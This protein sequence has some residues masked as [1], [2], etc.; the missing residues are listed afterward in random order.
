[1][2]ISERDSWKRGFEADSPVSVYY[3]WYN[4]MHLEGYSEDLIK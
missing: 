3:K 2:W 4:N 1:M